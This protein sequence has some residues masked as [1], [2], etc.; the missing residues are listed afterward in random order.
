MVFTWA[1]IVSHIN[2]GVSSDYMRTGLLF[3]DPALKIKRSI[4]GIQN[5]LEKQERDF[6]GRSGR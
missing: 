5:G 4:P 1:K 3:G 6:E 2:F